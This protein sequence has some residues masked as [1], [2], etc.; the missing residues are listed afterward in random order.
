M[1]TLKYSLV[2]LLSIF[3][4]T[5]CSS[6]DDGG[7][8]DRNEIENLLLVKTITA[9][10]VKVQLF[11]ESGTLR[12]G[13]NK[14]YLRV[15]DS[16]DTPIE[17]AALTWMPM[18]TMDMGGMTHEHSTP[19]S[20]IT[21]V[22]GKQTLYEGYIVFIMA[23]DEPH[24]YWDLHLDFTAN[25]RH[26]ETSD[27]LMVSDTE[28]EFNKPFASVMGN[29][30]VSYFLALVE[31]SEPVIG[32]NDIVVALFKMGEHHDF[33]IVN[34]YTIQVDPRMPGMGNHSAPGNVAMTQASDGFY[35]GKVGFSM[36]G[37][38]KINLILENQAG[39]TVKGEPVTESNPESSLHFKLEF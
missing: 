22:A 6:D 38:W 19:F 16:S 35:H 23:S 18:M 3:L 30:E 37:Y 11:T 25:S 34:N 8:D 10:D 28:S 2:I 31:P 29:D 9:D 14:L 4:F 32:T 17:D 21:K 36:T 7:S 33:P 39:D 20:E 15:L 12:V 26:F 13:Y 24:S 27:R 5:A 1:K